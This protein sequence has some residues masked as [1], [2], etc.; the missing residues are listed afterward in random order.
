MRDS[1][2]AEI[3]TSYTSYFMTFV[4][5]FKEFV[6]SLSASD[7][8]SDFDS[9][10]SFNRINKPTV[11]TSLLSSHHNNSSTLSLTPAANVVGGVH[12]ARL[13]WRHVKKWLH[14]HSPD[15][16]ESLLTPCTEADINE[17]QKD[18]NCRLPACVLEFFRLTDG[19]ASFTDNGLG[20]L[21]F[22]LKLMSIDEI[23]VLTET[24]RRVDSSIKE[25]EPAQMPPVGEVSPQES[26]LGAE[27]GSS[28]PRPASPPRKFS[29]QGSVPPGAVLPVYAHAMWIPIITDG[30]GNCIGVDLS[31]SESPRWGQVILFGRDFDTKFV[32]AGNFGDFLLIFANDLEKGNWE[33]KGNI[34]NDDMMCGVDADLV[35]VDH[36]TKKE[37]PYFDVLRQRSVETWVSSLDEAELSSPE[38]KVL[39]EHLLVTYSYHVPT[40]KATTDN[41]I[42][43]NLAGFDEFNTPEPTPVAEV[44]AEISHEVIID[45]DDEAK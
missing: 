14:K 15:L 18:L 16:N 29:K 40:F 44:D 35:Y 11:E 24:W 4:E 41:M 33:L 23:A 9:R 27:S 39:L 19:Q 17:F 36:E 32:V 21:F 28:I 45:L 34:E 31:D 37:I 10:K 38:N 5:Q 42:K 20:G 12:E 7:K 13:A 3:S 30:V 25:S 8:Y 43:E 2:K 1:P 26:D 6:Y 22:G